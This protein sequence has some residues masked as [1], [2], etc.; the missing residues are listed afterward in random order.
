MRRVGQAL[1]F[2]GLLSLVVMASDDSDFISITPTH[3]SLVVKYGKAGLPYESTCTTVLKS[4]V[5]VTLD[6]KVSSNA[7]SRR[8]ATFTGLD[9]STLYKVTVSCDIGYLGRAGIEVTTSPTP[10]GGA[11]SVPISLKPPS[12]LA[13]AARVTVDYGTTTAVSDGSVQNTSCASGCVVGLTLD[14]G[15][16]YYR[17]RW[18]TAADAVLATSKVTELNIGSAHTQLY[19][20][21]QSM[22]VL[23]TFEILPYASE[24]SFKT[25]ATV[26]LSKNEP[27]G[28]VFKLANDSDFPT[29]SFTRLYKMIPISVIT[30]SYTGGTTGTFYD[31][32]V[33]LLPGNL[34]DTTYI[35]AEYD[36][37]GSAGQQALYVSQS[38]ETITVTATIIDH[39]LTK[40]SIPFYVTVS[41]SQI[42]DGH[43]GGYA[44]RDDLIYPY[45]QALADHR[46][47]VK[48]NAITTPPI[49]GD[50]NL[51]F[52]RTQTWPSGFYKTTIRYIEQV[53][54]SQTFGYHIPNKFSAGAL[55]A[56]YLAAANGAVT[57]A[58]EQA[59]WYAMDEPK[60]SQLTDLN[61]RLTA[62][63]TY[64]PDI[65]SM[66]TVRCCGQ[67]ALNPEPDIYCPVMD[68]FDTGSHPGPADYTATGKELWLYTS[69]LEHGCGPSR[70]S[71]GNLYAP[72]SSGTATGV[73]GFVIDHPV[74][75]IYA[76]ILAPLH[77]TTAKALLYYGSAE[78]YALYRVSG[79]AVD[80]WTDQWNFGGNG[81]GTLFYPQRTGMYGAIEEQPAVSMR[82]KKTRDAEFL[83]D[84]AEEVGASVVTACGGDSLMTTTRIW[85]KNPETY[86]AF[87]NC[88][89]SAVTP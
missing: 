24:S 12:L 64:S 43:F 5:D 86:R 35:Y 25:S 26:T 10:A 23:D 83:M 13:T 61:A 42:Q 57:A 53:G 14:P 15:L 67:L 8:T 47:A 77:Y 82:M 63:N 66:V 50:G 41:G 32:M 3:N 36:G 52:N 2:L 39:A 9:A 7:N 74:S 31:A 45:S 37:A 80:V 84:Y 81:D 17:W 56:A 88:L 1:I 85:E 78:G 65:K 68:N 49:G 21:S 71:G 44:H 55:D 48:G 58:G 69:C 30:P 76:F 54:Q 38:G 46:I 33:P 79:G 19:P 51:D 6:T 29:T 40:N 16:N 72:R 11:V 59:W 22:S 70:A 34:A 18:Q 73:P 89:V 27:V 20:G 62:I 75:Y 60:A 87:R 28:Y 4:A